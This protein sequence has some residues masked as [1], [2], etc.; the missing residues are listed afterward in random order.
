MQHPQRIEFS[1]N[2]N[3]FSIG[4]MHIHQASPPTPHQREYPQQSIPLFTV[5]YCPFRSTYW[6]DAFWYQKIILYDTFFCQD[7]K[8]LFL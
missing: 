4:Q 6:C 1:D 2:C 3:L 5:F 8:T 7:L